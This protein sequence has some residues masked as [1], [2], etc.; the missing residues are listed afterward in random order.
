MLMVQISNFWWAQFPCLQPSSFIHNACR[1]K[2]NPFSN[3]IVGISISTEHSHATLVHHH[4]TRNISLL[5]HHDKQARAQCTSIRGFCTHQFYLH[6]SCHRSRC[7]SKETGAE[8]P[9]RGSSCVLPGWG[10]L[11][12][13][14]TVPPPLFHSSQTRRDHSRAGLRHLVKTHPGTLWS[15][16]GI[17]RG[18]KVYLLACLSSQQQESIDQNNSSICTGHPCQSAAGATS[19]AWRPPPPITT[20]SW[21]ATARTKVFSEAY[22]ATEE[23]VI[24][25]QWKQ[26]IEAWLTHPE[27]DSFPLVPPQSTN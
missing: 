6:W 26:K 25:L 8:S 12:T 10:V 2:K 16:V 4:P 17:K 21:R 20:S 5:H 11:G 9:R 3:F 23:P 14:E 24:N 18:E 1:L 19:P 27:A 7:G 15:A 22:I 13:P